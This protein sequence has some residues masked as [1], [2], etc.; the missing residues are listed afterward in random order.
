MNALAAINDFGFTADQQ[1]DFDALIK[2]SADPTYKATKEETERL[3]ELR[4]IA[5]EHVNNKVRAN[6]I[7]DIKQRV[8]KHNIKPNEIFEQAQKIAYAIIPNAYKAPQ[9]EKGAKVKVN[10]KD[11]MIDTNFEYYGNSQFGLG[12]KGDYAKSLIAKGKQGL[13]LITNNLTEEGKKWIEAKGNKA[14][15]HAMFGLDED[16]K[17]LA[18]KK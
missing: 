6:E 15:L 17:P 9:Y 10:G 5:T 14:K 12:H 18:K 1:A 7:A 8:K 16:L 11:V 3:K 13:S 2:K 4:A